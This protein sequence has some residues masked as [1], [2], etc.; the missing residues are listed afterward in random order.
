MPDRVKE[1]VAFISKVQTCVVGV[2]NVADVMAQNMRVIEYS[3]VLAEYASA[4]SKD[5]PESTRITSKDIHGKKGSATGEESLQLLKAKDAETKKQHEATAIRKE[6]AKQKKAKDVAALVTTG[7]ERLQVIEQQ[8]PTAIDRLTVHE[9]HAL[10]VNCDPQGTVTKPKTKR[11]ALENVKACRTV[12][13]ALVRHAA[14]AAAAA[15][16]TAAA[17]V[18]PPTQPPAPPMELLASSR[19][20]QRDSLGSSNEART[21]SLPLREIPL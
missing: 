5:K 21:P 7:A 6:E 12:Q 8:G 1:A 2:A 15:A 16:A 3:K 9:L 4:T 20:P 17:E 14:V 13:V 11:E 19:Q 18:P 10:L